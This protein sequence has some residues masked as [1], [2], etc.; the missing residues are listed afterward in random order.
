[1]DNSDKSRRTLSEALRGGSLG[2]EARAFVTGDGPPAA[3]VQGPAIAGEIAMATA[4]LSPGVAA[5]TNPPPTPL[6]LTHMTKL[7]LPTSPAVVPAI[8]SMTF[9]L[10]ASLTARLARVSAER[11][12]RRERPFH[13]QDIVAEAL[14]EWLRYHGV[15]D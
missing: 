6:H 8:V 5:P 2:E 7:T 4:A 11:K 9:R 12:L 10:P 15:P 3:P 13:Q 14:S 1:M